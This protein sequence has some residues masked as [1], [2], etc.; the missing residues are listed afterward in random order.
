MI[1]DELFN[2]RQFLVNRLKV[3]VRIGNADIGNTEYPIIQILPNEEMTAHNMNE[4]LTTL[5]M[6]VNLKIIVAENNE[7]KAFEMLDKMLRE[8]NQFSKEKGHLL[9][10]TLTPEY[11]EEKKTYEIN[12]LYNLKLLQ[13]DAN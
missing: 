3:N 2:L 13:H 6:P 8:V 10:G 12:V 5:D 7:V 9:E 11:V 1:F 4:R